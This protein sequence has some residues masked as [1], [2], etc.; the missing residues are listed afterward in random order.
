VN[1][2]PLLAE[3]ARKLDEVKLDAVS[4]RQCCRSSSRSS[5]SDD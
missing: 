2:A 1:A 4:Q 5:S 3:V